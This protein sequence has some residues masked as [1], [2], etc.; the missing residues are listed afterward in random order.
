MTVE[1][2]QYENRIIVFIDILGFKEHINK[3]QGNPEYF[4]KM[5]NTLN[6][7]SELK[8]PLWGG[9]ENGRQVTVFS[10]S[11]VISYPIELEGSVYSLLLDVIN[12]QLEMTNVGILMR[13]GLTFGDVCH[14]DNIVFGPAM[15]DA[16]EL[17]S[18]AANYPRVVINKDVFQIVEENAYKQ[19]YEGKIALVA[20]E[21]ELKE[22]TNLCKQDWDGQWYVDFL[23]QYEEVNTIDDYLKAIRTIREV[24]ITQIEHNPSKPSVLMKYGWL[25]SYFNDVVQELELP[26][27]LHIGD[28]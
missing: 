16:Y 7:I 23:R 12:I 17:E 21:G 10:D 8:N 26:K 28:E 15:I 2:E 1:L 9:E 11:I 18:K 4:S 19:A 25:R 20:V 14:K 22:V 24:I 6:F 3:T 5:R 27:E 13:G